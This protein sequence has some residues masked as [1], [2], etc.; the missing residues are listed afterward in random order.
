MPNTPRS[1]QRSRRNVSS[2]PDPLEILPVV[3]PLKMAKQRIFSHFNSNENTSKAQKGSAESPIGVQSRIISSTDNFQLRDGHETIQDFSTDSWNVNVTVSKCGTGLNSPS[4]KHE[5]QCLSP[6]AS[7]AHTAHAGNTPKISSS[8]RHDKAPFQSAPRF[9]GKNLLAESL[10]KHNLPSPNLI[11]SES[12]NYMEQAHRTHR[13]KINAKRYR[14]WHE[15]PITMK[16]D[17]AKIPAKGKPEPHKHT[18]Y[19]FARGGRIAKT[20]LGKKSR[21][22]Q[23]RLPKKGSTEEYFIAKL[24]ESTEYQSPQH[25][26]PTTPASSCSTAALT[27]TDLPE[28]T[29]TGAI[30]TQKLALVDSVSPNLNSKWSKAHW[31]LLTQLHPLRTDPFPT[32]K[33]IRP[34]RRIIDAFPDITLEELTRRMLA[35]DRVRLKKQNANE[36]CLNERMFGLHKVFYL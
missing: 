5:T 10:N 36:I 2:S 33:S 35:L 27:T 19:N 32:R 20:E 17:L 7:I 21:F 29:S 28:L 22:R 24:S 8:F 1:L 34:S 31:V 30:D 9:P 12:G 11:D 13:D 4:L 23:E 14:E 3:S 6:V 26:T 18:R 25:Q 15:L 16:A